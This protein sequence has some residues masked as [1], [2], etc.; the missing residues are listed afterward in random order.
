MQNKKHSTPQQKEMKIAAPP[1]NKYCKEYLFVL[2][3]IRIQTMNEY[4]IQEF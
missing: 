4:V 3:S 1:F 2:F